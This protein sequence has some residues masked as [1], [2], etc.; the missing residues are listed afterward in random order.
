MARA[1]ALAGKPPGSVLLAKK[2][3]R[4]PYRAEIK[5]ALSR[6]GAHFIERLGSRE[7][8]EAFQ[9]FFTRKR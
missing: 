7:A 1:T 8:A 4:D 2:L 6:E 9:A 5:A 3:L